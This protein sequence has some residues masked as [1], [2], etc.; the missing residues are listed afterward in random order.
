[1]IDGR[2]LAPA[3]AA[4][5]AAATVVFAWSAGHRSLLLPAALLAATVLAIV[6]ARARGRQSRVRLVLL[7]TAVAGMLGGLS[8]SV[9]LGNLTAEPMQS[10]AR[11]GATATV[12]GRVA[13]DPIRR[14]PPGGAWWP[15]RLEM[16]LHASEV[17]ARGLR[18]SVGVPVLIQAP[19]SAR[20]PPVGSLIA[21]RGRL[22]QSPRLDTA[23]VLRL[24]GDAVE[25]LAPP[26]PAD[27]VTNRM[28]EGLR[29][30]L[31]FGPRSG[32]ALVA[33]L[34]IGDESMQQPELTDAMR[35]SGLAHLTAVSGGNVAILLAVVLMA[36]SLMRIGLRGRVTLSLL[37][38]AGFVMLVR[39]EPSVVRAAIMGSVAVVSVLT[40]GRRTGPSI[41]AFAV[42]A[43]VLVFPMLAVSWGFALSTF[44]TAGLILVAPWF[45]RR[46]DEGP[47]TS[48]LPVAVRD[49][50]AVTIA[51]QVAT[52]PLLIAMGNAVGWVAVP[53][54]LLAMPAVA[55]VT[56]LG[57]GAAVV[58]PVAPWLAT[59]AGTLASWPGQWI[60]WIATWASGLPL[61]SLPWPSGWVGVMSLAIAVLAIGLIVVLLPRLPTGLRE[62]MRRPVVRA[63]AGASLVT[64]VVLLVVAPLDRRSWPP[65]GWVMIV[66]DVG[67]G[68]AL[69]LNAGGGSAV[70]V[71]TGPDPRLLDGCLDD[72]GVDD[73][74][75]LVLTH[76]HADH[77]DGIDGLRD[78]HVAEALVTT[79]DEPVE[80]AAR[81]F[82]WLAEREI[83]TT[84]MRMSQQVH[85]GPI[86]ATVRWPARILRT[87]SAP[88]N[89]SIV[90]DATIDGVHLLL[91][92]DIETAAQAAVRAG[93][94]GGF[95]VIKVPHHGSSSIDDRFAAWTDAR[96]ALV[97]V[98]E[99]NAF[100]H[101]AP[102]TMAM[103]ARQAVV[104]RTD[105][106]GD[107][108]V[109][110][111]PSGVGLVR[112]R[113]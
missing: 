92:G 77:V 15:A 39:P 5:I 62:V 78:R 13:N 17:S 43:V 113:D 88:N 23:A 47:R 53:A 67:Q 96:L 41:L 49:A 101:P 7:G 80:Q 46:L 33:G 35:A 2:L 48:R 30:A 16:R 32:A 1:M 34:A 112:R 12:V 28:R 61:A 70:I 83:A 11:A 75:L 100:G 58:S 108:A 74:P 98:G 87:G 65:D 25:V 56:I 71:D 6:L 105:L 57:L 86:G 52:L 111:T 14:E 18:V 36:S 84:R 37:A 63:G 81:T 8:A 64:I 90:L 20:L 95:D 22:G 103:W 27:A 42:L 60:A 44:A 3:L 97:S 38:I 72:S 73:V 29:A 68:D 89:A 9:Q 66:C 107:L 55:P 10:W 79:L 24:D 54:N 91:T 104:A 94:A 85:I 102:D 4:W 76:F 45:R 19:T 99:G 93:G 110:R 82:A 109:V 59:A 106:D 40:G 51:A 69:I 31:A 50:M 26:G 21:V